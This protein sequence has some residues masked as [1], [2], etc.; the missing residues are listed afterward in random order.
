M[1]KKAALA[2]GVVFTLVGIL[3]FVP[4][5]TMTDENGMQL[6]LGLFMV[7]PLHNI[8]HL[9]SGLV[10]LFAST[11]SQYSKYYLMGFGGVYALVAVVGLIQGD[12]VLGLI[13]VNMAD[14][15][16]HVLLAVGLLGA[17]F[18]LKDGPSTATAA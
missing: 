6:L 18:A 13:H 11:N 14:N 17:G 5:I 12:T 16:L 2:F 7:D 1:L 4:G 9:A 10:A 8:I 15:I 3:G